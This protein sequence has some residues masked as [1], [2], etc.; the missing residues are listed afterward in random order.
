[1]TSMK[2]RNALAVRR[3]FDAGYSAESE[4]LGLWRNRLGNAQG[5]D[6]WLRKRY[7]HLVEI[8]WGVR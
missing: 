8:V 7:P 5:W 3:L 4:A 1:M 6:G 2:V